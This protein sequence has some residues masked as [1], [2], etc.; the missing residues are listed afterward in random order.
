MTTNVQVRIDDTLKDNTDKIFE[1]L[2]MTTNEG[3]KIFLKAVERNNGLPFSLTIEAP[4]AVLRQALQ[5]ADDI[6]TGKVESPTFTSVSD[7]M[8]DL[9]D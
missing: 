3:I 7:L 4:N 5:E 1:A 9:D 8:A 6:A 2:G